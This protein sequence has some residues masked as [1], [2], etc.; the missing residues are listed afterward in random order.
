MLTVRSPVAVAWKEYQ[1]SPPLAP[2]GRFAGRVIALEGTALAEADRL[3]GDGAVIVDAA[4]AEIAYRADPLIAGED[5]GGREV[6]DT[7]CDRDDRTTP[8]LQA[9]GASYTFVP[10]LLQA[11]I[12]IRP[13]FAD[14]QDLV[15]VITNRG[16][17]P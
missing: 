15:L 7:D 1:T 17:C 10:W 14:V 2:H 5:D 16:P 13:R 9:T 3:F 8:D 12:G 4:C 11:A 6:C